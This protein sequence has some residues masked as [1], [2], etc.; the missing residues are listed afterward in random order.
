MSSDPLLGSAYL[1]SQSPLPPLLPTPPSE[2]LCLNLSLFKSHLKSLRALDD[3]IIL[4]LNRSDA[5]SRSSDATRPNRE[6]T[7]VGKG[8]CD[9]FWAELVEGWNVRGDV[10][11]GCLEVVDKGVK[12]EFYGVEKGLDRDRTVLGRGESSLEV[13]VRS[14]PPHSPHPLLTRHVLRSGDKCI[15]N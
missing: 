7:G 3:S 10:L 12:K 14:L 9:A 1:R 11:K 8:E 13:K 2:S 15:K 6:N 4:R 5:L